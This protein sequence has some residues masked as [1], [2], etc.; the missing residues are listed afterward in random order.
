M[1]GVNISPR[2]KYLADRDDDGD[3]GMMV[4][5]GKNDYPTKVAEIHSKEDFRFWYKQFSTYELAGL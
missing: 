3:I 4:L 1:K 5:L 2:I